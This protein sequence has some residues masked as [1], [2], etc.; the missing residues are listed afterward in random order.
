MKKV[1]A[2]AALMGIAGVANATTYN[3]LST[4]TISGIATNGVTTTK[5]ATTPSAWLAQD[6]DGN[7]QAV[8]PVATQNV[9][10]TVD[11]VGGVVTGMTL[12]SSGDIVFGY[13]QP[14]TKSSTAKGGN[15]AYENNTWTLG[16]NAN[17]QTLIQTGGTGTCTLLFGSSA[18]SSCTTGE[19]VQDWGDANAGD[20][21]AGALNFD[22]VSVGYSIYCYS[23]VGCFGD[24]T[25]TY[26]SAIP[27]ITFDLSGLGVGG[28]TITARAVGSSDLNAQGWTPIPNF[29][30][31]N[32]AVF[33]FDLQVV[34]VPAA[35][36]LFG[37]A[38]G[39]MGVARRHI[40]A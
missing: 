10:G 26:A 28:G 17:G 24:P 12:S 9:V 22:G 33:S 6:G 15:L 35:V 13:Y 25:H 4:S 23:L 37:S 39:L 3:I 40:A 20:Y 7:T 2:V 5:N 16:S 30:T 31:V 36:W 11:I 8:E 38:L 32:T 19:N 27:G 14:A 18:P 21:G 34:P 29:D 1:L